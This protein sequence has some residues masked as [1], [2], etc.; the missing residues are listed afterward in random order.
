MDRREN[1]IRQ[2]ELLADQAACREK[3]GALLQ[4][5]Q[6]M[7]Q[8]M[9]IARELLEETGA[10]ADAARAEEYALALA[11]L[12]MQQGNMHGADYCYGKALDFA[13]YRSEAGDA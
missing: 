12:C 10:A 7:R 13:E 8:A 6:L 2:A 4:A 9:N 3:Q 11:D 1:R 5:E